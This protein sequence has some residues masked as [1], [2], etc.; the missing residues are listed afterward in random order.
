LLKAPLYLA[1]L[2]SN[3]NTLSYCE[4][5]TPCRFYWSRSAA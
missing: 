1:T 2:P 3:N 5:I 4:Y